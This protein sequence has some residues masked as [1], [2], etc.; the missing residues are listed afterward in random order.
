MSHGSREG[1]EKK[2]PMHRWSMTA[3]VK[4]EPIGMVSPPGAALLLLDRYARRPPWWWWSWTWSWT[5]CWCWCWCGARRPPSVH[6]GRGQGPVP[7]PPPPAPM[8]LFPNREPCSVVLAGPGDRG[9]GEGQ[10]VDRGGWARRDGGPVL[11]EDSGYCR[12]AGSA[13]T[14]S[15]K[16]ATRREMGC[17]SLCRQ[18]VPVEEVSIRANS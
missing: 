11:F 3:A 14:G 13:G 12:Q 4:H 5:W 18:K 6:Q 10:A 7:P 17:P 8:S 9:G 1:E 16:G 2:M 15:P